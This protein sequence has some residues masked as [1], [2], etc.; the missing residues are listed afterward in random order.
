MSINCVRS[1]QPG[2]T[3]PVTFATNASILWSTENRLSFAPEVV[4]SDKVRAFKLLQ[5]FDFAV[6]EILD[7]GVGTGLAV[8]WGDRFDTFTKWIVQ[9][10]RL[11]L[12]PLAPLW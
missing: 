10:I 2:W 9:P 8:F 5:G 6:N 1:E 12:F 3:S 7:V 11:T 4:G